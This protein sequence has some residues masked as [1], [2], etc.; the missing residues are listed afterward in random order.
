MLVIKFFDSQITFFHTQIISPIY[1]SQFNV[2]LRHGEFL[3]W[4]PCCIR[5]CFERQHV[6]IAQD[7]SFLFKIQ[8]FYRHQS[9][10][11]LSDFKKMILF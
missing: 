3:K 6:V 11:R 9:Q 7:L 4:T 1:T 5:I 10:K 2:T 8:A